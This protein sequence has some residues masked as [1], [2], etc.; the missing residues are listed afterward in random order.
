MLTESNRTLRNYGFAIKCIFNDL[1]N[2]NFYVFH[3]DNFFE[4]HVLSSHENT[5]YYSLI[6]LIMEE[7]LNDDSDSVNINTLS[8]RKNK[9]LN[10]VNKSNLT[11]FM[12][13]KIIRNWINEHWF[14]TVDNE[15]I[16]LGI[17]T[18]VQNGSYLVDL[19]GLKT[20]SKCNF[21]CF[22]GHKCSKCKKIIHSYCS[23]D[24]NCFNCD[25]PL[26]LNQKTL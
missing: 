17:R 22:Y 8:I 19:Y 10:L 25:L 13:E 21:V 14:E 11:L 23:L 15:N 1:S 24:E 20:C 16:T 12:V 2:E 4:A 5:L 7:Y 26:L 3:N 6:Q 18:I 9:A